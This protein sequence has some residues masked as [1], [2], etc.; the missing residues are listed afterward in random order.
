LLKE[1]RARIEHANQAIALIEP[2]INQKFMQ[3]MQFI[4]Q[5]SKVEK[6][7]SANMRVDS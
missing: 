1:L 2:H 5:V 7:L 6:Q 4:E 3:K